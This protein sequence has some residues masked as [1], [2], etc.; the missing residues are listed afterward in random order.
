V[1]I[2]AERSGTQMIA[3]NALVLVWL[4]SALLGFLVGFLLFLVVAVVCICYF[5]KTSNTLPY[6][7]LLLEQ[8]LWLKGYSHGQI[9][10]LLLEYSTLID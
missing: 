6:L 8:W 10:W 4:V 2:R 7:F 1:I 9:G 3:F 5:L